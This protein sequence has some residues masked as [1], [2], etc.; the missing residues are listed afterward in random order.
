MVGTVMDLLVLV[1]FV[2]LPDH[3]WVLLTLDG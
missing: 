3:F 2:E 1:E